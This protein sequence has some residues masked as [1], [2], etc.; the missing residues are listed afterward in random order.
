VYKN[1]LICYDINDSKRLRKVAKVAYSYALGGQK[2]ALEA[3]LKEQELKEL[4]I[5]V[6]KLINPK[7]DK[8]N[9]V[10]YYGEP[11]IYGKNDFLKFKEGV[12]V[13]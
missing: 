8:I 4:I 1:Y 12:I 11:L 2:S 6:K 7:Q 3:P 9:I 10:E 5:Q 13:I